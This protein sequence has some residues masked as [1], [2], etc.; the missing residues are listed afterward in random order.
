MRLASP[1]IV[2]AMSQPHVC[3][4]AAL[5]AEYGLQ[6][7][8]VLEACHEI[9][10]VLA[11]FSVDM[12]PPLGSMGLDD[13][14]VLK[15]RRPADLAAIRTQDIIAGG[16]TQRTEFKASIFINTQKRAQLPDLAIKEC[17]DERLREKA[18]KEIAALLNA[19]GGA[20]LFGVTDDR[21]I[22]GCKEDFEAF[23]KGGS[24]GDK[25]DLIIKQLVDKYFRN[26]DA[27]FYHLQVECVALGTDHVVVVSVAPREQLTFL[28][29]TEPPLYVRM[30]TNAIPVPFDR[31]EEFYSLRR[32]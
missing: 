8:S 11:A 4:L 9:E 15:R 18:A 17:I 21:E 6:S 13:I 10:E 22:R 5:I 29:A 7:K 20:I 25:A 23:E 26:S 28:K 2:A 16:E 30:G 27:V 19:D 32:R 31:I 14:R 24:P 12:E 1:S 3:T